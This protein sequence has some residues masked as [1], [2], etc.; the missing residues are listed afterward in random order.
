V[1]VGSS[2]LAAAGIN[3]EALDAVVQLVDDCFAANH[4]TVLVT[5][6]AVAAGL[7]ALRL[8]RRPADLAGLQVAAAVGQGKL[9]ERYSA[10]FS[11][12]GRIAGQ[13]LL[14]RDVLGN[15]DQYLNARAALQRMLGLGIVPV[16]N[17]NDTVAVEELR[18]GDNDRL[19]A[20]VSHLISA[21][22]LLI[23]TDTEGL[24][25]SDPRQ[26]GGRLLDAVSHDDPLLDSLSGAGPMGSGGVEG[27]VAAARMAAWS[28]VP[29]VIASSQSPDL[30]TRALAGAKVGT[31]VDPRP[32]KLA[33]RKLW[34]AFG[35]TPIGTVVVDEGAVSALVDHAR[36]LLPVGVTEV[37]GS[38]PEGAAVEIVGPDDAL[39][40]KGLVAL[41]SVSLVGLVGQRGPREAVHRDDLVVLR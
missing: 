5:S 7:P 25:T 31:W 19:A 8:E 23:L 32:Q 36:S 40:G 34:I 18:L 26:A 22:L 4:P 35:L 20:M 21:G 29:T 12:L 17:E 38:F 3:N 16:V 41:D 2:S 13:V 33:A 14:T 28:A 37:R 9:M 11:R 10:G 15:R 1:K 6:G 30:L 27:K 39:V 24:Y